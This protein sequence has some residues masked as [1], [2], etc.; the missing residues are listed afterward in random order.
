MQM[1]RRFRQIETLDK[2]LANEAQRLRRE[3]K[4][5]RQVMNASG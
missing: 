3:A 4:P 1:R 2:R 5:R